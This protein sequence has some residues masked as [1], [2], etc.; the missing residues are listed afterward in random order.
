MPS[1]KIRARRAQIQSPLPLGRTNPWKLDNPVGWDTYLTAA[2]VRSTFISQD[3][4]CR[5]LVCFKIDRSLMKLAAMLRIVRAVQFLFDKLAALLRGKG[6]DEM[7]ANEFLGQASCITRSAVDQH[8]TT[9]V[10]R[11]RD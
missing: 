7:R 5:T 9:V 10:Q 6:S 8:A 1:A 4:Q 11:P 3:G 2:R